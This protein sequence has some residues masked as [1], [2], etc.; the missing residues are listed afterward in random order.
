[1]L[2]ETDGLL[3]IDDTVIVAA[4]EAW[5]EY[6]RFGV[7]VCQPERSFRGG[8]THFGFYANGAIQD[9]V[10]CIGSRYI[11][12]SFTREEST[13][14]RS[15]GETELAD[16]I[17]LLLGQGLRIEGES[18][19]VLFLSGPDDPRTIRLPGPIR[20]DTVTAAGR[21]WGWTLSQRYTRLDT[22]TSGVTRLA[23]SDTIY[24]EFVNLK[25]SAA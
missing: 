22:L 20:N 15:N 7:Y 10:A 5:P 4:R 13:Q 24:I 19:D 16:M 17:D 23:S 25:G 14:R 2:Y 1:M 8:L 12:V 3:S 21:P 18:Y 6:L 9:L 11:A